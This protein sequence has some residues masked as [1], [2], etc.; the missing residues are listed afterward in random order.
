MST[1]IG[2][3]IRDLRK[4]EKLSQ[5]NLAD[6]IGVSK[7]TI[8]TWEKGT[9]EPRTSELRKLTEHPRFKQYAAWLVTDENTVQET[10]AHYLADEFEQLSKADQKKVM[11]YM[12]FLASKKK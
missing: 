9:Y 4:M 12:E 11:E 6:E 1:A 3:K 8:Y 5:Q 7:S 2:Q 10:P